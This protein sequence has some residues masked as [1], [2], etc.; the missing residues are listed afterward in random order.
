MSSRKRDEDDGLFDEDDEEPEDEEPEVKGPPKKKK[1]VDRSFFDDAAEESG[2]EGGSED[3]DEESG[4][5]DNNDYVKDDFVVD[6]DDDDGAAKRKK[7]D[8]EDSDEDD[9][10]DSEDDTP[11]RKGKL[12]KVSKMRTQLLEDDLD[13][14]REARG[15]AVDS[16][17]ELLAAEEQARKEEIRARDADELRRGLFHD[18]GDEE[19]AAA[20]STNE[21]ARKPTRVKRDV[22]DEEGLDDFIEDDIGD[23]G[24]IMASERM[25]YTDGENQVSEAQLQEASEIFGTDY[26]EF[27]EGVKEEDEEE[28]MG[29]HE[30]ISYGYESEEDGLS[31]EDDEDA[32]LFGEDDDGEV[33]TQKAEAIRMKREKKRLARAERRKEA[34]RRRAEKRKAKLRRVFEPVQLVENFCT[35]RDD[36]I[37]QTDVPERFFDFQSHLASPT[38]IS[39]DDKVTEEEMNHAKW[40]VNRIEDIKAEYMA[41]PTEKNPPSTEITKTEILESIAF[42]FRFMREPQNLE[43]AFIKRYRKDYVSS[44]AVREH[45][46]TLLDEDREYKRITGARMKVS[47]LI[48]S[49]TNAAEVDKSK[50]ADSGRIT[51]L[52][53]QLE[54]SKQ[55][56]EDSEAE[57]TTVRAELDAITQDDDEDELFGDDNDDKEE[58]SL[59]CLQLQLFFASC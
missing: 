2:E 40:M 5:E 33:S 1:K 20:T 23:Q 17:A 28:L 35:D 15:E 50:G 44:G 37:R 6:E 45:L 47:Q 22:F 42:A 58:V 16:E 30:G 41:A 38:V 51:D 55:Q 11:R 46:Y 53:A 8:L 59:N 21:A 14:V 18:S 13:L 25:G 24:D 7:D 9:E 39:T 10:D 34:Q 27:M 56:V 57:I 29:K 12:K 4:E 43:P 49:V 54:A 19:E 48:E 32:D 3:E 52:K 26:L 36:L 31:D